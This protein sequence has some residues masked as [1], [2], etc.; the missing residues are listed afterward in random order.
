VSLPAL[1]AVLAA[2]GGLLAEALVP[3]VPA[4]GGGP[5]AQVATGPRA[6]AD[7]AAYALV[8]DAI[9]EGYLLHYGTA[10]VVATD[11]ADLALLAGDRLYALGLERLAALG[12][13]DAVDALAGVI[14][15]SAQAHATGDRDLAEAV[16][17]AGVAQVGWGD[18]AALQEARSRAHSG[19]PSAASALR[20]AARQVRTSG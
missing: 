20:S 19:D 11:D 4:D 17:E 16:W 6:A 7:P 9:R 12:D 14:A 8:V 18:A 5:A 13:L 1:H 10:R 15:L 3:R 2:D